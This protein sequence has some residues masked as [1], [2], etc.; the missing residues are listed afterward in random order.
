MHLQ[1]FLHLSFIKIIGFWSFFFYFFFISH[2]AFMY[3]ARDTLCICP[4]VFYS[5]LQYVSI[6][7]FYMY[8]IFV[9]LIGSFFLTSEESKGL[10]HNFCISCV[11]CALPCAFMHRQT[12]ASF[13]RDAEVVWTHTKRFYALLRV[14]KRKSDAIL[15]HSETLYD[16]I[17]FY[18][19]TALLFSWPSFSSQYCSTLL[20]IQRYPIGHTS[21]TLFFAIKRYPFDHT[22]LLYWTYAFLGNSAN[23][24]LTFCLHLQKNYE[25]N[26]WINEKRMNEK[27]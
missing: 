27:K 24:L 13:T 8:V 21:A 11:S 9:Q 10:V 7:L 22:A 2:L 6:F 3:L 12:D 14:S 25:M 20:T 18:A 19:G 23:A 5:C 15:C 17:K 16:S 26:E 4:Y 1:S